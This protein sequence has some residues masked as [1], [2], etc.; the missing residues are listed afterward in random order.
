MRVETLQL[1]LL[2]VSVNCSKLSVPS[3]RVET[4]QPDAAYSNGYG[5]IGLSVPSMRVETLQPPVS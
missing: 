1:A 4:L 2:L 5:G 3:M